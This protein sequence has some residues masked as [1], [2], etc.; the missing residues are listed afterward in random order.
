MNNLKEIRELFGATQEDVAKLLQVSRVTISK[1][2][3]DAGYK[4]SDAQKEKLSLFFYIGPEFFYD[5]KLSDSARQRI[6]ESSRKAKERSKNSNDSHHD[7]INRLLDIPSTRVMLDYMLDVKILLAKSEDLTTEQLEDIVEVNKKL[8]IR[9]E[10][11]LEAKK[12]TKDTMSLNQSLN[13]F[14]AKYEEE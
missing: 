11:L 14:A 9:L 3:N 6:I 8:G 5:K 1:A 4:L 12:S 10:A 13:E 7:I 2:E